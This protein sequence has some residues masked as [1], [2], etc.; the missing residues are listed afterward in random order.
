MRHVL[1]RR[2]LLPQ[3]ARQGPAAALAALASVR[4]LRRRSTSRRALLSLRGPAAGG[5][6]APSDAQKRRRAEGGSAKEPKEGRGPR[7]SRE[8]LDRLSAIAV[9]L[10]ED[11]RQVVRV[12]EDE[13]PSRCLS[14]REDHLP[15][16]PVIKSGAWAR[17]SSESLTEA[18]LSVLRDRNK[19]PLDGLWNA[20]VKGSYYFEKTR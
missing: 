1:P 19:P 10:R 3:L 18:V 14:F 11:L 6:V 5:A 12:P 13:L 20:V 15:D 4:R 7:I 16:F 2:A 8:D 17:L 9:T